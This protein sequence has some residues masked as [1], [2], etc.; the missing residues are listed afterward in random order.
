MS[1]MHVPW[2]RCWEASDPA[3]WH[4][5]LTVADQVFGSDDIV[6]PVD[7]T[8]LGRPGVGEPFPIGVDA[9]KVGDEHIRVGEDHR[10][11]I[12]AIRLR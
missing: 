7:R 11:P 10:E 9:A 8:G 12:S 2:M 4:A 3:A 6:D 5:D 1:K